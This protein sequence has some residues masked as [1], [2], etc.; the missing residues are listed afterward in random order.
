[1]LVDGDTGMPLF[2]PNV[3]I[4]SII[5]GKG[6]QAA[7]MEAQLRAIKFLYIWGVKHDIDID[8]RFQEG[9]F[10]RV[11]EVETLAADA[12]IHASKLLADTKVQADVATKSKVTNL[13]SY[14]KNRSKIKH[15]E[16]VS[17]ATA[18]VRFR[19]IRDYLEW[20]AIHR[21]GRLSRSTLKYTALVH[22]SNEMKKAFNSRIPKQG[23]QNDLYRKLGLTLEDQ[24][25]L[26]E[27]VDPKNENNPWKDIRIR[28]RNQLFINMLI[29]LGIRKGEALGIRTEDINLQTNK[30]T[31]H[32]TPND[33]FDKRYHQPQ[34]KTKARVLPLG[35]TLVRLCEEYIFKYRYKDL[36]SVRKDNHFLFVETKKGRE[37][38]IAAANDIF[39]FIRFRNP[40]IQKDLSAHIL[41]HTWN[42]RFSERA[43]ELIKSGEWTAEHERKARCEMMGWVIDSDMAWHYSRRHIIEQANKVE[44]SLQESIIGKKDK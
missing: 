43:D 33:Q 20:L 35:K 38:S 15:I 22:A 8:A 7:T 41:R 9:D 19:Y 32:R 21:T 28:Y 27:A 4:T 13:N 14:K 10:L 11:Y 34:T 12:R 5:R 39:K 37:L 16:T 23:H 17:G 1:M 29:S 3:Y 44:L 6:D 31:I 18:G 36:P 2:Y 26:L 42:D 40:D 30:I 25:K 24:E